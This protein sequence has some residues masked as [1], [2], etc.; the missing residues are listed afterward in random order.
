MAPAAATSP[1]TPDIGF[2][3][4]SA[5]QLPLMPPPPAALPFE[6]L[7]PGQ[8]VLRTAMVIALAYIVIVLGRGM[9]GAAKDTLCARNPYSPHCR[10]VE[11][12][13]WNRNSPGR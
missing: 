13:P 3:D 9:L 10:S 5:R 11:E 8:V 6:R 12:Q 7:N 1:T 4:R 2:G